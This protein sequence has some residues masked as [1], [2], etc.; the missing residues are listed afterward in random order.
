MHLFQGIV[1]VCKQSSI[2]KGMSC[3]L[4]LL[5]FIELLHSLDDNVVGFW[6]GLIFF[7]WIF[8]NLYIKYLCGN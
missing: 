8:F 2:Y 4:R 5:T 3:G 7:A 1:R 6:G